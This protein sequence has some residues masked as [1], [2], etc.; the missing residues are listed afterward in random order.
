MCRVAGACP[1]TRV[2]PHPTLFKL[3][4]LFR[5]GGWRPSRGPCSTSRSPGTRPSAPVLVAITALGEPDPC[6]ES[7]WSG[8][9]VPADPR[10]SPPNSVQVIHIFPEQGL[11][12]GGLRGG[13]APRPGH[14]ALD[15]RPQSWWRSRHSVL[16]SVILVPVPSHGGPGP[17]CPP[18]HVP[19]PSPPTQLCSGIHIFPEQGLTA[20]GLRGGRAPRPGHPALDPRPQSWWRSR[21]SVIL[22]LVP[23]HGGPRPGLGHPELDPRPQ[24]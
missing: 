5:N 22:I 2:P 21:H 6:A 18:T 19:R 17:R 9:S 15:P 4:T 11:T 1:V 24:S 14:P 3:F 23:S 10:P 7:R 20:G 16:A 8:A 12:A 13:R